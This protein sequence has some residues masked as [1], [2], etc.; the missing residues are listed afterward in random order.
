MCASVGGVRGGEVTM[1]AAADDGWRRV[2]DVSRYMVGEVVT[3]GAVVWEGWERHGFG[4]EGVCVCWWW[5]PSRREF[6]CFF[7]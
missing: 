5:E 4:D 1:F 3:E 7:W 6:W 2:R